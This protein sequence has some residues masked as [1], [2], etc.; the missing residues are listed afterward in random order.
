LVRLQRV[1][2]TPIFSGPGLLADCPRLT[3]SS[4]NSPIEERAPPRVESLHIVL[5]SIKL[6]CRTPLILY[7]LEMNVMV[8]FH[9]MLVNHTISYRWRYPGE[10]AA[11]FEE[12]G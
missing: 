1:R 4:K 8:K 9:A 2:N 5:S 12:I 6:I 10:L 7:S 3:K 11:E